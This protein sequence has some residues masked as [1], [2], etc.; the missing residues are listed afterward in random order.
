MWRYGLAIV[1]ITGMVSQVAS[2]QAQGKDDGK[3]AARAAQGYAPVTLWENSD[4]RAIRVELKPMANRAIHQH[5][6]V[7]FHLFI[8]VTGTLQIKIRSD[9]PV[10]A[11]AGQAFYIKAGTPHGFRNLGS[12]PG[13]AI[14]I[15]V[16]KGASTASLDGLGALAAALQTSSPHPGS[17]KLN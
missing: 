1:A 9:K 11:P 10:D 14:E 4:V 16:K 7:K 12:T 3:A 6:D 8:P 2:A 17:Q 5:D 15:F 13:T